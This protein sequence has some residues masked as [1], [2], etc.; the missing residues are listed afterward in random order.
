[1]IYEYFASKEAMLL[2]LHS[3]GSHLLA[4]ALKTA[5]RSSDDPEERLIRMAEAYWE[6]AMRTP[7]LYQVMH[8]LSGVPLDCSGKPVVHEVFDTT[9]EALNEWSQSQGI[10][11]P[12][13]EDVVV[14]FHAFLHGLVSLNM[15]SPRYRDEARSRRLV[16]RVIHDLL[17][18]WSSPPKG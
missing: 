12:D 8:R 10:D 5:K 11:L 15:E 17:V 2:A 16:R 6:C 4:L 13:V 18:S 14:I 1:M 9:V 7:E 3:E